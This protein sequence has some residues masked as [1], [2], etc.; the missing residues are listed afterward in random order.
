M[1]H[2]AKKRIGPRVPK[3]TARARIKELQRDIGKKRKRK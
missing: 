1:T 3:A 2:K